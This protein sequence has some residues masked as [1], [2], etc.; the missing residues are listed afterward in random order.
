MRDNL[1]LTQRSYDEDEMCSD[2]LGSLFRGYK[3]SERRGLIVWGDPW[4]T[5]AWEVSDGFARKWSFLLKGC[6]E[7]VEASNKWR[8]I[9]GEEMLV[10]EV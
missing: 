7:L 6:R 5:S 10:V 1:I 9:R 2:M 3:G 4:D 8:E